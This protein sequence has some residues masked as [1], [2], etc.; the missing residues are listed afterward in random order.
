MNNRPTDG[1]MI[2]TARHLAESAKQAGSAAVV[3]AGTLRPGMLDLARL[4]D[5][6]IASEKFGR[7]MMG[8]DDPEGACRLLAE[9]DNTVAAITL[10]KRGYVAAVQGNIIRGQ[11]Y[12]VETVDTTGCGDIFHAGYIHGL[13]QNWDFKKCLDYGAWAAAQSARFLGGREGIPNA[14]D[15][16]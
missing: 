7:A 12:P 16:C 11:A 3:D 8:A 1:L 9:A 14:A 2:D 5:H 4:S 15:Y 13:L 10:G 6:F